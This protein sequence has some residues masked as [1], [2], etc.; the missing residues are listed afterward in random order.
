[1]NNT[2][3]TM[4]EEMLQ[5]DYVNGRSSTVR[6]VL[7]YSCGGDGDRRTVRRSSQKVPGNESS[8]TATGWRRAT[9]FQ[10]QREFPVASI[11]G[12]QRLLHDVRRQSSMA[13]GSINHRRSNIRRVVEA[14]LRAKVCPVGRNGKVHRQK[15][16]Y[17]TKRRRMMNDGVQRNVPGSKPSANRAD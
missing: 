15:Q 1:M 12:R 14:W 9:K 13:F 16:S 3:N 7:Q 6:T 17:A 8:M 11:G 5:C 4:K 2:N 10:V